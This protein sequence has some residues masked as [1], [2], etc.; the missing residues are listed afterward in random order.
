MNFS[1]LQA[2]LDA[3]AFAELSDDP[4][5]SWSRA[6]APGDFPIAAMLEAGERI[7]QLGGLP[8]VMSS[9]TVRISAAEV[10]ARADPTPPLEGDT[11]TINGV[12]F[13]VHGVAYLDEEM[14][15]RDWLV[16]VSRG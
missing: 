10:S 8:G 1:D 5:A 6:R 3:T 11:I 16:P 12:R 9:A 15:G 7:T 13:V 4:L 2:D 14:S